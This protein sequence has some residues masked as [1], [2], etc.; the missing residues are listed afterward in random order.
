MDGE[1]EGICLKNTLLLVQILDKIFSGAYIKKVVPPTPPP[2]YSDSSLLY[3]PET[4]LIL[5]AEG[6]QTS[7]W[8]GEAPHPFLTTRDTGLASSS[9]YSKY[10]FSFVECKA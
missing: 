6:A 8:H 1:S 2:N 3:L 9:S 4:Y 5:P 7:L 10:V